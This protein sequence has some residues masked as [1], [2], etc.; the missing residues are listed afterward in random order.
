MV[1][2]DDL[3]QFRHFVDKIGYDIGPNTT[4]NLTLYGQKSFDFFPDL[5]MFTASY[6]VNKTFTRQTTAPKFMNRSICFFFKNIISDASAGPGESTWKSSDDKPFIRVFPS[7]Y[8]Y[9]SL[10]K[11]NSRVVIVAVLVQANY[12]KGFLGADADQFQFLFD[13]PAD[14]LLEEVMTDDMLSTLNAIVRKESPGSLPAYYY[15]LKAMELL[16]YLFQRLS[17]REKAVHQTFN[18]QD[19]ASIYQVRD[20]L[21]SSLAKPCSITELKRVAGMNELK[22]RNLFKQVFGRGIYDYYQQIR[23]QEAARLLRNPNQSV[24]EVGAQLGYE[25]LSHFSR[26]FDKYIGQKPKQ[27]S[28]ALAG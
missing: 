10:F 23:M 20:Q 19:I 7:T 3:Q 24:S 14:F 28:K 27:Y 22:M 15:R 17:R 11:E 21:I 8:T 25:N 9:T 4:E 16:F 13:T 1:Y 2:P 6:L 18:E 5:A 26:I 12:L